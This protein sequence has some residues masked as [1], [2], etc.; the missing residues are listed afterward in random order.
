MDATSEP[1]EQSGRRRRL[2]RDPRFLVVLVLLLGAVLVG[3]AVLTIATFT[4]SSKNTGAVSAGSVVFDV[5]PVGAALDTT[6]LKPGDTRSGELELANRKVRASFT[7][8]FTGKGAGPLPN[9]LQLTV[10]K[11]APVSQQ[12]FQGTLSAASSL[13]LGTID[14]G[15]SIR[16]RFTFAWP[17]SSRAPDLQGQTVPLVLQWRAT[18]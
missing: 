17:S 2:L 4:A 6:N 8:D 10:T 16:L 13:A 7:L 3:S 18:T 11:T 15:N 1:V 12:L 9:V 14:Q 5:T